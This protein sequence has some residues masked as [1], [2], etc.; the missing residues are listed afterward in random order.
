M[1]YRMK[2]E[3]NMEKYYSEYVGVEDIQE[4]QETNPFDPEKISIDTKQVTMETCLRRIKQGSLILKPNFQRKEVWD[5]KKKSQ[6]I[7]S[8]ML[9]IPIPMFYVS[10]DEKG[11]YTV[12]DG[13]QRL[14]TIR[15]FILGIDY[16]PERDSVNSRVQGFRL[17]GLEFWHKYNGCEF[18]DLPDYLRNRI[19]ETEFTF[20]IIN[21]GTPELVKLNIFK[22]IN[23]GGLPLSGQEIRNALYNGRA[24]EYLTMLSSDASFL[25]ATNYSIRS[26][27]LEDHELILRYLSFCIRPYE[28]YKRSRNV[29]DFLSETMVIIN[30]DAN[31]DDATLAKLIREKQVIEGTYERINLEKQYESF[32]KAM[33]RS[34]ALFNHHAFRKSHGSL[35]KSPINKCLFEMWAV[36]LGDID[37]KAFEHIV[38]NREEFMKDY[39]QLLDAQE[40]QHAISRDS[41][42][43]TAVYYRFS[44]LVNLLKNY[45]I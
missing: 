1:P 11:Y 33:K 28:T 38:Q 5:I 7:E 18:T 30:A 23:T 19:L 14:S 16:N 40:F 15:D 39:I 24:T 41:M 27:R 36:L 32:I 10:S 6:L 8:L 45:V 34:Y 44:S 4:S 20:T 21:P 25:K 17:E 31:S 12:V 26:L 42:K 3:S 29:D 43:H 2:T 35:R 9:R 22:R 13:L 37:A